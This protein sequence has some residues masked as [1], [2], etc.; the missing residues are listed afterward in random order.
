VSVHFTPIERCILAVLSDGTAHRPRELL[1]CLDDSQATVENMRVHL[2][3]IRAKL[4]PAGQ[5]ILCVIADR[6]VHYRHVQLLPA[7]RDVTP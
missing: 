3:R 6:T 2:S 1:A 5:D 7:R 4:R